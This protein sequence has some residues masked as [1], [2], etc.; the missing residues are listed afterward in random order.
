MPDP[1]IAQPTVS[2]VRASSRPAKTV[3]H[4]TVGPAPTTGAASGPPA[5]GKLRPPKTKKEWRNFVDKVVTNVHSGVYD[6]KAGETILRVAGLPDKKNVFY[7]EDQSIGDIVHAAAKP[8]GLSRSSNIRQTTATRD[9]FIAQTGRIPSVQ[10]TPIEAGVVGVGP[11]AAFGLGRQLVYQY[12]QGAVHSPGGVAAAFTDPFGTAGRIVEHLSHPNIVEDAF[13]AYLGA[14]GVAAGALRGKAAL[15]TLQAGGGVR[16]AT[17]RSAVEG[18]GLLHTPWAQPHPITIPGQRLQ[19]PATA[20]GVV[21][22][23][24]GITIERAVTQNPLVRPFSKARSKA[25]QRAVMRETPERAAGIPFGRGKR[26]PA[27]AGPSAYQQDVVH[28]TTP[29]AAAG[30]RRSGFKTGRGGGLGGDDY[31]PGVYLA[32]NQS[33]MGAFWRDQ[34]ETMNPSG[35]VATEILPGRVTLNKPYLFDTYGGNAPMTARGGGGYRINLTPRQSLEKNRPDLLSEFDTASAS[36]SENRAFG[37]VLRDN[38]YDGIVVTRQAGEEIVAFSPSKV[39]F[40]GAKNPK[41]PT[42]RQPAR[43]FGA[44]TQTKLTGTFG[45]HATVGRELRARIRVEQ[46]VEN[47]HAQALGRITAKLKPAERD[48]LTVVAISGDEALIN[49]AAAIAQQTKQHQHFIAIGGDV[50]RNTEHI[51]GLQNALDVLESPTPRFQRAVMQARD[52]ANQTESKL[53]ASGHLEAGAAAGRQAK[54]ADI[55][56]YS[57][58][59]P[60]S[61]YFPLSERYMNEGILPAGGFQ[62]RASQYGASPPSASARVPGLKQEFTG[63]QLLAGRLP[64]VGGATA[65][66]A[67]QVNNLLSVERQ[68]DELYRIGRAERRSEFDIPIRA[69]AQV[70]DDLRKFISDLT[71]RAKGEVD[72]NNLITAGDLQN[73]RDL[74][75]ASAQYGNRAVGAGSRI[76]GIRWVDRRFIAE[77]GPSTRGRVF[78]AAD[79]ITNP[80]RLTQLYARPAY[81]LNLA[82]NLGM[83]GISEGVRTFPALKWAVTAN[84]RTSAPTLREIDGGMGVSLSRIASVGRGLGGQISDRMAEF[85]NRITDMHARR[86][87]FHAAAA[88]EG[89]KTDAQIE[90]LMTDPANAAAK[91]RV[92]R[93]GNKNIV[94]YSSLTPF[95]RD[96]VRRLIYFYPWVSRGTIWSLRTLVEHPYKSFT[97]F[98][99][100]QIGAENAHKALGQH[101]PT[102]VEE[103][104]L[105]PL[106]AKGDRTKV[107]NPSSVWTPTTAVQTFGAGVDTAKALIGLPHTR[108]GWG[109]LA[110]PAAELLTQSATRYEGGPTKTGLLGLIESIP[111]Y[112]AGRRLGMYGSES[113]TYPERG[114]GPAFGPLGAG[115]FYPRGISRGAL[116]DQAVKGATTPKARLG[117]QLDQLVELGLST[118]ERAE[119]AKTALEGASA[120]EITSARRTVGPLISIANDIGRLEANGKID[121]AQAQTMRAGLLTA[122]PTQITAAK[123]AL[124]EALAR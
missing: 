9:A 26:V 109:D 27:P 48:A 70:K 59:P 21:P 28:V 10:E 111:Y 67:Q 117:I 90:K 107:I 63:G 121:A 124:K 100:G 80:V 42:V 115:G 87:A 119:A 114:P 30:I 101:Q 22:R 1:R 74:I 53:V 102:W 103:L 29:V 79:A 122:T 56:G 46:E 76:D 91:T 116:A 3:R 62:P 65:K 13:L 82:G 81:I 71:Q 36:M 75:D 15:G 18:G 104:G 60:G 112:Q 45:A 110:T 55:Y 97:L 16:A 88:R 83:N 120:D 99:L 72:P 23:A 32:D 38:G 57:T 54:I 49:P 92:F 12:G 34:I 52:V 40:T 64:D 123:K 5:P 69:T 39:S 66:R 33:D 47:A 68:F 4:I 113:K 6:E 2:S 105:I 14:H 95:E 51:K 61:F 37:K 86:A 94:D 96:E 84:R 78:N 85:W 43:R 17:T 8:L 108:A 58:P 7:T 89:F 93:Q 20:A 118:P 25:I 31:G 73:L 98:E 11:G 50:A 35:T 19:G 41:A 106:G 44:K 77:M 24:E